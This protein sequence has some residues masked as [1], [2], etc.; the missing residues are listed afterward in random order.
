MGNG[1]AGVVEYI[2][3]RHTVALRGGMI[4]CQDVVD[5]CLDYLDGALPEEE[6][7]RFRSH[8]SMCGECVA[9]FE[10]YRRTPEVSRNALATEMPGNVK[11]AVRNYLRSRCSKAG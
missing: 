3:A 7:G 8:L 2:E 1:A 9:F 11:D 6:R 5:F 4:T 10:T